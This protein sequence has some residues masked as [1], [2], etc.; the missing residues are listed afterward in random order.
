MTHLLW[1]DRRHLN[2]IDILGTRFFDLLLCLALRS[3]LQLQQGGVSAI[4]TADQL[5]VAALFHY[6]PLLQ[7]CRCNTAQ[8]VRTLRMEISILNPPGRHCTSSLLCCMRNWMMSWDG[9]TGMHSY[10]A[11]AWLP[12]DICWLQ[13]VLTAFGMVTEH[14]CSTL[15]AGK[16]YQQ[17]SLLQPQW[18]AD[19]QQ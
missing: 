1:K 18:I 10:A 19:V 11:G 7:H 5:R 12:C 13:P 3:H 16:L 8:E 17:L 14:A 9:S 2:S 4:R 15:H 6:V